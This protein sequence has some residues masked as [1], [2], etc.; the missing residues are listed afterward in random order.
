MREQL[1]H[2]SWWWNKKVIIKSEAKEMAEWFIEK[3]A[4]WNGRSF[5]I[6]ENLLYLDT[7]ASS[8][9]YGC[10]LNGDLIM[11]GTSGARKKWKTTST[12]KN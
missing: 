5:N 3:A 9:G 8:E 10:T 1:E 12:R 7:D 4:I 11:Q 6:K 2:P